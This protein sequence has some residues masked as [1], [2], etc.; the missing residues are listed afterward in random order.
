[1]AL[2]LLDSSVVIALGKV[3]DPHHQ[4]VAA[5]VSSREEKSDISVITLSELL[6]H[7]NLSDPRRA[8][9]AAGEI[10]S[11]F[12]NVHPVSVAVAIKA[13]EIRASSGLA[14]ADSIISATALLE[15]AQLWTCDKEQA[16]SNPHAR[17][18]G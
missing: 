2:V 15:S 13:S 12:G 8:R 18:L 9:I 11:A 6:I 10:I 1:M 5:A 4:K 17:Y 14:L 7:E 3:S 16:K